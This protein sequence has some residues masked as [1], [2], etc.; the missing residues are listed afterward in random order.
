MEA[1]IAPQTLTTIVC[2]LHADRVDFTI[3]TVAPR[4]IIIIVLVEVVA[5]V[6]VV[7]EEEDMTVTATDFNL[8]T[9]ERIWGRSAPIVVHLAIGPMI[10]NARVRMNIGAR[11]Q[12][13]VE[14]VRHR[15]QHHK[16]R[17]QIIAEELVL[18]IVPHIVAVA[19]VLIVV[20]HT[21]DT[22]API[23]TIQWA[24]QNARFV[25]DIYRDHAVRCHRQDEVCVQPLEAVCESYA[26]A[27][28]MIC[29]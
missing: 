26:E 3:I 20:T 6:V 11:P 27:N 21:Q 18:R 8:V 4:V 13:V 16:H 9:I 24:H 29:E 15:L 5:E 10:E 28:Q 17:P 22:V 7:V 19:L 25:L 12:P 1:V 14:T 2:N 23:T